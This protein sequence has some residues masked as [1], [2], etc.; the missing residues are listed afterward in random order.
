MDP[1]VLVGAPR[2]FS[3]AYPGASEAGEGTT[4]LSA[5]I[6]GGGDGWGPAFHLFLGSLQTGNLLGEWTA[7]EVKS[8]KKSSTEIKQLRSK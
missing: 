7:N 5:S 3:L 8:F 4:P 2:P 1:E 6:G